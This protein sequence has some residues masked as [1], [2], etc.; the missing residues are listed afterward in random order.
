MHFLRIDEETYELYIEPELLTLAPFKEVWERDTSDNK[1]IAIAELSF[2][3]YMSMI[4]S[5]FYVVGNPMVRQKTILDEGVVVGLP[6]NWIPDATVLKCVKWARNYQEKDDIIS[7]YKTA[8][9]TVAK[10]REYLENLNFNE[11]TKTG[12]LVNEPKSV[13]AVLKDVR[14]L[15][16]QLRN[17]EIDVYTKKNKDKDFVGNEEKSLFD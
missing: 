10:I 16:E 8:R 13:A 5:M 7:V 9:A 15:T 14:A 6:D 4:T 1:E 3:Y 12:T 2:V 11:R 17:A